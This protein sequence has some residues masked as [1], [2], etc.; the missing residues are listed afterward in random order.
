[1][2]H[3][4]LLDFRNAAKAFNLAIDALS[5][6]DRPLANVVV[7]T[8]NFT[9]NAFSEGNALAFSPK[10]QHAMR[11]YFGYL[12]NEAPTAVQVVKW[13]GNGI[14][15]LPID[16]ATDQIIQWV[17][18][19]DDEAQKPLRQMETIAD[20]GEWVP[21][22]KL[23]VSILIAERLAARKDYVTAKRFARTLTHDAI[24]SEWAQRIMELDTEQ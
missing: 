5:L 12:N 2:R 11:T 18:E 17:L 9:Q 6:F 10:L 19:Q 22:D 24:F 14:G 13:P 3:I 16:H 21:D 15:N 8:I 23:K 1:M 4:D 20:S 7:G